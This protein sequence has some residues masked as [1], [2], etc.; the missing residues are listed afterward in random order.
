MQAAILAAGKSSRFKKD[1]GV[2]KL[3]QPLFGMPLLKRTLLTARYAGVKEF[4]I[5]V[6][7]EKNKI[8]K[9]LG[10]GKELGVK[11]HYIENPEWE[12]ENGISF[13]K[14]RGK[15]MTPF[16]LLMG[17]HVIEP[18]MLKKFLKTRLYNGES[19]L[20]VDY[21]LDKIF[22]LP[23][24][25]KVFVNEEGKIKRI[26]KKIKNFN[27]VDTG[28]FLIN[29]KAFEVAEKVIASGKE[30]LSD[31]MQALAEK[32][33][34]KG[35]DIGPYLWV[36]IDTVKDY[37]EAERLVFT[38][39][40]G[41]KPADGPV[42]RHINRKISV[43]ITKFLSRFGVKPNHITLV[44]FLI[45]S[46]ASLPFFLQ[47][48]QWFIWAAFLAQFGSIIDG[49]DGELARLQMSM[50][51]FGAWFDA[52][53][54]RVA[55]VL[56]TAG[57]FY[58]VFMLNPSLLVFLIGIMALAGTFLSSYSAMKYNL[59]F[60]KEFKF[61]N[62]AFALISSSRDVRIF[63]LFLGIILNQ[64]LLALFLIALFTNL[65]VVLRFID[66]LPQREYLE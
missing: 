36:D 61:S 34:L 37:K 29:E 11:I 27:A 44:S 38:K 59:S 26:G 21:K 65:S 60:G 16:L 24:A 1:V 47:K 22:D 20:A 50:T 48:E 62:R 8:K 5:V 4:F 23:E 17:D 45:I 35:V 13:Y 64:C 53:L 63:V 25:T 3:L 42:S 31:I 9:L 39:I 2:N 19:A 58:Y 30:R 52:V 51:A 66:T 56:F 7:Y 14:L 54:D 41:G 15:I 40:I 46:L 55:D 6:G 49:C 12:K 33:L 18:E 32:G 28:V 43:P 10:K 57:V